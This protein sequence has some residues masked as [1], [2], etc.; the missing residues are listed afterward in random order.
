MIL[1]LITS[2]KLCNS[3]LHLFMAIIL[4]IRDQLN[5]TI[6]YVFVQ[7]SAYSQMS[8]RN[9]IFIV[10]SNFSLV[11]LMFQSFLNRF[12]EVL[13]R[14]PEFSAQLTTQQLRHLTQA[15]T[16]RDKIETQLLSLNLFLHLAWQLY[17]LIT[18]HF[19]FYQNQ[20]TRPLRK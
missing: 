5:L 12:A 10:F 2:Y 1:K 4:I 7:I 18:Q 16:L 9:L 14:Q 8:S 13:S 17:V 6:Y 19:D 3:L 15:K 20:N 11:K